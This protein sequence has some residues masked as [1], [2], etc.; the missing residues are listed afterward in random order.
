MRGITDR[1]IRPIFE[2]L[3]TLGWLEME[4]NPRPTLPPHWRVNPAVQVKFAE[5]AKAEA[6]RRAEAKEAIAWAVGER[7]AE[8][9]A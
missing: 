9:A 4:P 1:D 5:C 6:K 2:Q 7:R 8:D 3:A